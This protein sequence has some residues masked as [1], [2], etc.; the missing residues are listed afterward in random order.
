MTDRPDVQI[1]LCPKCLEAQPTPGLC[2]KDGTQLLT[3]R[4]GDP[5]DPCRRPLIDAMGRLR[6]RAPVWWLKYSVTELMELLEE[7][8]NS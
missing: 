4:P 8:G 5:D 7:A 6:T 1:H 2:P 3:C